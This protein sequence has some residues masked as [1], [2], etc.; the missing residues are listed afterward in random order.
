VLILTSAEITASTTVPSL[1]TTH[2][3]DIFA[4]SLFAG[5]SFISCQN[6]FAHTQL[7]EDTFLSL[8]KKL[9]QISLKFHI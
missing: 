3:F 8:E 1:K 6:S 4:T 7:A 9:I 5:A 2:L